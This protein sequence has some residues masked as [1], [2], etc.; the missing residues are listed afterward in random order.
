MSAPAKVERLVNV[1]I[2]LLEA[3][4]PL[5]LAELRQRTGYYDQ[6]DVE[7]GRRMFERDKDELRRLGVPIAT[8]EVAFGDD[9]GYLIDRREYELAD[10]DLTSDEVAALAMAVG[11]TGSEALRLTWAR[12]AARAPDPSAAISPDVTVVV[13][14]DLVEVI[15]DPIVTRCP[16]AFDYRP[17]GGSPARRTVDPYAVAQRR[18]SWYLVG[19]DHERGALRTFRVD[20]I[21]S[22][23]AIVGPPGS[24]EAPGSLNL[25][26]A[27]SI[28]DDQLTDVHL[29]VEPEGRWAVQARGGQAAPAAVGHQQHEAMAPMV[30]RQVD[31]RRQLNWLL[32]L[33]PHVVP[34]APRGLVEQTAQALAAVAA[35]HADV[36]GA[37]HRSTP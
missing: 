33:V 17:V 6:S 5:T 18:G 16:V 9:V 24:F 1:T 36:T 22:T 10:L 13:G 3:R 25:V 2:A 34:T 32:G 28:P 7:S 14:T 27:L 11:M 15:A 19:R 23:V 31:A 21:A 29:L 20:R 4:R 37:S 8:R 12:L 26:E 35:A 30:L